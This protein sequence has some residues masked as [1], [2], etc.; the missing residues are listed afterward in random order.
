MDRKKIINIV[1][2]MRKFLEKSEIKT[3][4]FDIG[5]FLIAGE[6]TFLKI[7]TLFFFS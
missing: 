2:T 7:F 5:Y 3:N 4:K 1:K 6:I